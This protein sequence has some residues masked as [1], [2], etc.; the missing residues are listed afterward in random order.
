MPPASVL[1]VVAL[2]GLAYLGGRQVVRGVKV[3]DRKVC[4]VATL[5]HKCKPKP[6]SPA[7]AAEQK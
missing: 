2:A 6:K 1:V 3:V 7:T 5:G 4:H